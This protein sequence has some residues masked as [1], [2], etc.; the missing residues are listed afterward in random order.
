M[1]MAYAS[2]K[3]NTRQ[4]TWFRLD[5]DLPCCGSAKYCTLPPVFIEDM[6]NFFKFFHILWKNER[7]LPIGLLKMRLNKDVV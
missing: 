6:M 2:L 3:T 5:T 1:T 7:K 4:F